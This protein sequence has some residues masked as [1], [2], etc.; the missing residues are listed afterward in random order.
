MNATAGSTALEVPPRMQRRAEAPKHD[1]LVVGGGVAGLTAA[2]RL[3]Q[4]G[5]DVHLLEAE[6]VHLGGVIR[7]VSSEAGY[8]VD[9]GP[10]TLRGGALAALALAD[11]LGLAEQRV[12]SATA[13]RRRY[14]L[15]VGAPHLVGVNPLSLLFTSKLLT[16]RGRTRMLSEAFRESERERWRDD[17]HDESVAVFV[18]RR[19]GTEV[20]ERLVDPVLG[21]IYAG[22]IRRMSVRATLPRLVELAK[23]HGRIT[24]GALA[25]SFA[26]IRKRR[27]AKSRR[28]EDNHSDNHTASDPYAALKRRVYSYRGGLARLPEALRDALGERVH[29]ARRVLAIQPVRSDEHGG[30]DVVAT[31]PGGEASRAPE[32]WRTQH[33]VL[34]TPGHQSARLLAPLDAE[35][36]ALLDSIEYQPMQTVA[37]GYRLSD[38]GVS[39]DGFGFLIPR[40][41]GRRTLGAIWTSAVFPGRAPAGHV[42]LNAFLG[43]ANDPDVLDELDNDG[44]VI[45]T[46]HADLR[47]PLRLTAT[48]PAFACVRRWSHA[49]PLF[50]VGHRR[51]LAAIRAR[52]H[53]TLEGLEL[54]GAYLD[55]V[56]VND[57]IQSGEQAAQRLASSTPQRG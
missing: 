52:L 16:L 20:A 35:L 56:G 43:G 57:A 19:F 37:L 24:T 36:A 48:R 34:A 11:E 50:S 28:S 49:L 10:N 38:L 7:S 46:V 47:E 21:G 51:R 12:L 8:Q 17:E 3:M 31:P 44:D 15:G 40:L 39:L 42:L 22:D 27:E 9:L 54:A 25:R 26:G 6:P 55:G 5:L 18:A 4:R 33:L 30:Y 29:T 13:A 23:D 41:A 14:L 45:R 53:A 1:V 32:R 2:Y